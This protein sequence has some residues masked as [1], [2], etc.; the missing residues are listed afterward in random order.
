MIAMGVLGNFLVS[1]FIYLGFGGFHYVVLLLCFCF[2]C[3]DIQLQIEIILKSSVQLGVFSRKLREKQDVLMIDSF[4]HIY[5][6]FLNIAV[7]FCFLITI[8]LH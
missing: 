2:I 1:L 7:K 4:M 8:F 6:H 5:D 3:I